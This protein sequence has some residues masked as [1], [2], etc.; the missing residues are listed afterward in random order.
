MDRCA[1]EFI[2]R[3][4]W[5]RAEVWAIAIVLV[6]GGSVL[7]YQACYWSLAEKQAMEVEEIRSAYATAMNERDQRLD[8][9]TR[10]TG[11]AAEKASKAATT[12]TQAADK[13]LEAVDRVSQ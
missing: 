8:E 11:T 6:A 12:A 3:R 5:R 1:M 4:W 2:A 10:K 9:L 7:G 13:A